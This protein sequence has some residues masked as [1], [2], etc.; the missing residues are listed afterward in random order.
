MVARSNYH[1]LS[2]HE[3]TELCLA[4]GCDPTE[5]AAMSQLG[6]LSALHTKL[7]LSRQQRQSA[8]ERQR[9]SPYSSPLPSPRTNLQAPPSPRNSSAGRRRRDS[10][11]PKLWLPASPRPRPGARK[12]AAPERARTAAAGQRRRAQ[13]PTSSPLTAATL[14]ELELRC[15]C[16]LRAEQDFGRFGRRHAETA[17][18]G[19]EEEQERFSFTST[20]LQGNM[21]EEQ[22][23]R[24]EASLLRHT[25]QDEQ[26][27]AAAAAA[28]AAATAVPSS[29]GTPTKGGAGYPF[30][31][32]APH[33]FVTIEQQ[34]SPIPMVQR[35]SSQHG[36]SRSPSLNGDAFQHTG[37][38]DPSAG[39]AEP[40]PEPEPVQAGALMMSSLDAALM[41]DMQQ[42]ADTMPPLGATGSEAVA[43]AAAAAAA[44]FMD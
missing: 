2:V 31:P 17:A 30:A 24:L 38:A 43:A 33:E 10:K 22:L 41:Q 44:K 20:S 14:E 25:G 15:R 13:Q 29:V 16:E 28:A 40:E 37:G 39:L 36:A 12:A 19:M 5:T 26:H 3:L 18:A 1:L 32:A 4:L 11:P 42:R 21:V 23:R 35:A 27:V 9:S 6:L 34:F 8:E 7:T